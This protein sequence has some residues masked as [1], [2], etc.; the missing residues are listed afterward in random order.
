MTA[1]ATKCPDCRAVIRLDLP[2]GEGIGVRFA[3]AM[4]RTAVCDE[5]GDRQEMAEAEAERLR[6]SAAFRDASQLPQPY[7]G[8]GL[9]DLTERQGQGKAFEA[10]RQWAGTRRPGTL[11]LTGDAGRGKTALAGAAL[12]TRTEQFSCRYASVARAMA[13]LGGSYSD[14][15]RAEAVRV[16]AGNGAIVLDDLDK[17]RTSDFGKAQL[18][19]AVDGRQQAGAALLVTTN[20]KPRQIGELFGEP[21]MSRLA[22]GTNCRVVAVGGPDWRVS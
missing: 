19:A 1:L 10:L 4:A 2:E 12:W 8:I 20:L 5:C 13:A 7:R 18:F 16:F 22:A 17:C 9:G 6:R 3:R 14:E 21:L 15:G 11:V